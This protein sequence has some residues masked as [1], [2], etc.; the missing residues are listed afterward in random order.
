MHL[1]LV[2]SV[3]LTFGGGFES[4][5]LALAAAARSVGCQVTIV[6][7]RPW[8]ARVTF[9]ALA[10][11]RLPPARALTAAPGLDG[12]RILATG[13]LGARRL[14]SGA[15]VVYGKN[16]PHELAFAHLIRSQGGRSIP[17]VV[18]LHS[19]LSRPGS[20]LAAGRRRVY[21][22]RGY[23]RL[24]GR[25]D[26]VHAIEPAQLSQLAAVGT[27]PRRGVHLIPNGVDTTVFQ[28]AAALPSGTFDALFIG[29]LD[30]QKGADTVAAAA[31]LVAQLAPN[32]PIR[33]LLAG[34]GVLRGRLNQLADR[35]PSLQLLGPVSDAAKLYRRCHL[36]LAPS[37]WEVSP[38]VPAEALASG[39]PVIVSTIA[40]CERFRG[41]ATAVPPGD[42]RLLAEQVVEAYREWHA[43]PDRYERRRTAARAFALAHLDAAPAQAEL[44]EVLRKVAGHDG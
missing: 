13:P 25:A 14:V 40:A 24:L 35:V 38:L 11:R 5:V 26:A 10:A 3:P 23:G 17:L 43:S 20:G 37:R 41:P 29:R 34:T 4:F 8:I 33:F 16:E 31:A 27:T 36:V 19:A 18:G 28:P 32:E 44:L 9:R 21:R 7:P 12:V 30:P 6:A 2:D 22:S 42:A 15:D 1:V 39:V